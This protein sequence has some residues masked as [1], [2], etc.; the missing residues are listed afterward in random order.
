MVAVLT[1]GIVEMAGSACDVTSLA[2]SMPMSGSGV[3][4][5]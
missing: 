3:I 1:A 5:F 2:Q 4:S